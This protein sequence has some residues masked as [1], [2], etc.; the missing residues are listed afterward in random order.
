[1]V[2]R[3]KTQRYC[4]F[5]MFLLFGITWIISVTNYIEPTDEAFG[6]M[7]TVGLGIILISISMLG[8]SWLDL[9]KEEKPEDH[10]EYVDYD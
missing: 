6:A 9:I 5:I 4:I 7:I 1:M 10:E 3:N 8:C 2:I